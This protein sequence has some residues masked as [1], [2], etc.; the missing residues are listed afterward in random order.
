MFATHAQPRLPVNHPKPPGSLSQ[1]Q[2]SMFLSG[3]AVDV[4]CRHIQLVYIEI[5]VFQVVNKLAMTLGARR[6]ETGTINAVHGVLLQLVR[7]SMSNVEACT[8]TAASLSNFTKWK[9]LVHD[10]QLANLCHAPVSA[11]ALRIVAPLLG[12]Y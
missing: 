5:E 1:G 2:S 12:L 7:P 11:P 3:Q 10:V 4:A 9:R 8:S 6:I